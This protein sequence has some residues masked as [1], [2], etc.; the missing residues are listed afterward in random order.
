MN[1]QTAEGIVKAI[2]DDQ[3]K[4]Q[5]L[6]YSSRIPVKNPRLEGKKYWK[7][8]YDYYPVSLPARNDDQLYLVVARREGKSE[9]IYLL[10][11]VPI[12][13]AKDALKWIKGYFSRWGILDFGILS[14]HSK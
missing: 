4:T 12:T 7:L 8:S 6:R 11:S 13:C 1:F 5:K 3:M 10:T 2:V 9:P 14:S